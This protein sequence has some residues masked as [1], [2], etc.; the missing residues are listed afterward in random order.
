MSSCI[1]KRK[2]VYYLKQNGLTVSF[3]EQAGGG[4]GGVRDNVANGRDVSAYIGM[5]NRDEEGIAIRGNR[6]PGCRKMGGEGGRTEL[7][8]EGMLGKN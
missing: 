8:L 4:G 3:V 2:N 1:K 7:N 5:N 6:A